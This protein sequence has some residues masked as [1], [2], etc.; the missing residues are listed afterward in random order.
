MTG[1]V[2]CWSEETIG[3]CVGQRFAARLLPSSQVLAQ[4]VLQS[5]VRTPHYS[6]FAVW[7]CCCLAVYAKDM[8]LDGSVA[9]ETVY[10]AMRQAC[11]STGKSPTLSVHGYGSD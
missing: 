6:R 9:S 1:G 11:A 5:E 3:Q 7:G 8:L 10:R 2:A 4:S